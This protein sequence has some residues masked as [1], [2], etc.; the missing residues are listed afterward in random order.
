MSID[1]IARALAS[2][3]GNNATSAQSSA[4]AASQRAGSID[5]FANIASRAIDASVNLV[6][7]G[8]Y[9]GTGQ[10]AARYV[11]DSLATAALA[12]SY[13]LLCKQSADGRYWRAL[14][15][16]EGLVPLAAAGVVGFATPTFTTNQ[17]PAIQQVID[18]CF[19]VGAAGAVCETNRHYCA[20]APARTAADT[21]VNSDKSG[22]PFLINRSAA[23]CG[24]FKLK[25]NGAT[26]WRRMAG[27]ADPATVGT[28]QTLS[29]GSPWRGGLF[30]LVGAASAPASYAA[31]TK[32]HL[33]SVSLMGGIPFIS[34][35]S[36]T[37]GTFTLATG[38]GWDTSDK[39][40]WAEN[41]RYTGDIIL[42][43]NITVDGFGGEHIYQGGITHGSVYQY[44]GTLVSSN[45]NGD[46]FNPCPSASAEGTLTGGNGV[47]CGGTVQMESVRIRKC[48]QAVEGPTGW[49]SRI[50]SLAIEDCDRGNGLMAGV[51]W[52]ATQPTSLSFPTLAINNLRVERSGYFSALRGNRI[53][54]AL[55]VYTYLQIGQSNIACI[56]ANLDSV[57]VQ[58]DKA[59]LSDAV[60]FNGTA[61]SGSKGTYQNRIRHLRLSQ[62]DN[63]IA[64]TYRV[65]NPVNYAG[66]LGDQN[67]VEKITGYALNVPFPRTPAGVTDYH[68]GFGDLSAFSFQ[69]PANIQNIETTPAVALSDAVM[70][71]NNTSSSGLFYYTMPSM[72]GKLPVGSRRRVLANCTGTSV[73]AL[74]TTNTRMAASVLH[75]SNKVLELEWDGSAW[76]LVQAAADL[77]LSASASITWAAVANGATSAEQTIT[78]AGLKVA[79]P[80]AWRVF[81]VSSLSTWPASV[82]LNARISADNT[83]AI[84]V[85]NVSGASLTPPAG[86]ITV[87]AEP[88]T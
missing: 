72:S 36:Y 66:S 33:D 58:C 86:T 46:G 44:G 8:G 82:I 25:G 52:Q 27:G 20:W 41:D 73:F 40:I 37:A 77:R 48:F 64:N 6:S 53:G 68:V 5:L 71:V 15:D 65:N 76:R 29:G 43:G 63:A 16:A 85:T 75:R 19:A 87:Y 79:S 81:A 69:N 50:G 31:R 34:P 45:S 3:A 54:Q 30:M 1:I 35:G 78:L 80:G 11:S 26:I 74:A 57:E 28:W 61:T 2:Q 12:A 59:G 88:L 83:V 39:P 47:V 42:T 67:F 22:I 84:S 14:P 62:S 13:P 18:Y 32:L 7:T 17:Q 60:L 70:W 21:N 49:N 56:G 10:G 4:N 23:T 38:Q 55:L 9:A 24:Y 51:W